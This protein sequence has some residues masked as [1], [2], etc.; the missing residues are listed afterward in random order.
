MITKMWAAEVTRVLTATGN[1]WRPDWTGCEQATAGSFAH[2]TNTGTGE[3]RVIRLSRDV[4]WNS[5]L[6]ETELL[7][8][9]AL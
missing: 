5:Q 8:Q 1:L 4:F 3:S 7:R 6:R 2:V 9:L